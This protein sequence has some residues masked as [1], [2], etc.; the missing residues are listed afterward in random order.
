MKKLLLVFALFLSG[1]AFAQQSVNDYKYIILPRA[2]GF[3]K[4]PNE[5]NLS[6]ISKLMFEKYGFEVY[7]EQDTLPDDMV[8]NRC[9]ALYGD[10]EKERAFLSTNLFIT[11]KDCRGEL[12]FKSATGKSKEKQFQ[13]AYYEAL[14][15]ASKSLDELNYVYKNDNVLTSSSTTSQPVSTAMKADNENLLTA[16]PTAYGYE[17]IDVKKKT[18]LKMYKTSQ[19]DYYS[20]KMEDI[21]GVVFKKDG[22]WVFEFYRNDQLVS[23]KLNIK[24]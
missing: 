1:M 24:F 18:A 20:A 4:E 12:L 7:F 6:Q 14:R 3:M 10:V 19:P 22:N 15:E 16:V 11:L 23:N 13:R 8:I 9:N 5:F 2:F 17:L 21:N